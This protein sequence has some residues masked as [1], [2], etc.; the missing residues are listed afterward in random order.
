MLN[1]NNYIW[2]IQITMTYTW[3][4]MVLCWIVVIANG[5][6][7]I[8]TKYTWINIVVTLALG[9]GPRQRFAKVQAKSEA[10]KSH[11]MLPRM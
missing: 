6:Y 10:R 2:I 7:N 11:F 5:L 9:L 1:H 3:T 8:K 4:Q